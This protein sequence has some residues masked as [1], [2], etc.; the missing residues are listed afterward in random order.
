MKPVDRAIKTSRVPGIATS[1]HGA[2]TFSGV[3]EI[4][5]A[6]P[7][8]CV[9]Y[10]AM[11]SLL[12]FAPKAPRITLGVD[13]NISPWRKGDFRFSLPEGHRYTPDARR[14]HR[15][16]SSNNFAVARIVLAVAKP[17]GGIIETT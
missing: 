6:S 10:P 14:V 16:S 13:R 15:L 9:S 5:V 4:S 17:Y 8:C 12:G 3:V 2:G 11:F 1:N 7:T